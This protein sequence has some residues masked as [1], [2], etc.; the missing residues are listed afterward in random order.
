MMQFGY[1]EFAFKLPEGFELRGLEQIEHQTLWRAYISRN[2]SNDL[3]GDKGRTIQDAID[4]ALG[5]IL[6]SEEIAKS[7]K[8]NDDLTLEDLDITF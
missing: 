6:K 2:N 5:A 8:G 4:K 1:R 3:R 7:Y